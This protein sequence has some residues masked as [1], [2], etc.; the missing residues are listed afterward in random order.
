MTILRAL[1]QHMIRRAHR[2]VPALVLLVVAGMLCVASPAFA[3]FGIAKLAVSARNQDGTPD[4]QAGSHPYALNTTIQ[5]SGTADG[6]QGQ[7]PKDIKLELPP[8]LVGDP[9][10]TP[11]CSYQEFLLD[12]ND[13]TYRGPARAKA[14]SDSRQPSSRKNW[15]RQN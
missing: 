5:L 14:P 6:G 8:G 4:V 11:K 13:V 1:V 15:D 12:A 9:N 3:E 7:N 2:Y 10:A